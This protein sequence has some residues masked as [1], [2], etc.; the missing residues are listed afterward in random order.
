LQIAIIAK[1]IGSHF[2]MKKTYD[3]IFKQTAT[4]RLELKK[5]GGCIGCFGVP[6]FLSGLF[7]ILL[8]LQIVHV[9]N[10]AEIPWWGWVMM[11][12]MGLAFTAVGGGLIFGRNWISINKTT[13]RIWIAWGLLKPM[14]GV[15]YELDNYHAV[16]LKYDAGDSDRAESYP[17]VLKSESGS[18]ELP[19]CSSS[20]YNVSLEQAVLLSGFMH[21]PLE[22]CTTDHVCEITPESLEA[23][24]KPVLQEKAPEI[25]AQPEVMRCEI[26]SDDNNLQ[27]RIPGPA[28]SPLQLVG[29]LIPA[30]ILVFFVLPFLTFFTRS[31][32]PLYVQ[33]FFGGFFGLF[34]IVLPVL[35]V[36]KS[37]VRSKSIST[38]VNV[39]KEGITLE[40]ITLFRKTYLKIPLNSILGI[41]YSTRESAI[42]S[43]WK[44]MDTNDKRYMQSG[45]VSAPANPSKWMSWLEKLSRS[46]GIIIKSKLGLHSFGAGLPDAEVYHLYTLVRSYLKQT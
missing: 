11:L 21:L 29:L 34:M 10:A 32:T 40:Q 6:F 43:G 5:G 13:R 7:T 25:S 2:F 9:S 36:L 19:L 37:I 23:N 26:T 22:D 41:D 30:A 12:F 8:S 31:N 38:I 14:K 3:A 24:Q 28:F 42:A 35:Q 33:I 20:T 4:D 15:M 1:M 18:K 27:I 44:S 45:G 39:S 16:V 17:V 46:K